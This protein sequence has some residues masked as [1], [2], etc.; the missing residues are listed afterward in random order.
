MKFP[1]SLSPYVFWLVLGFAGNVAAFLSWMTNRS[2][3]FPIY[4]AITA[5]IVGWW[6]CFDEASFLWGVYVNGRQRLW[7]V[8]MRH[9]GYS[10]E[11]LEQ[12]RKRCR[13]DI[14]QVHAFADFETSTGFYRDVAYSGWY[15]IEFIPGMQITVESQG[16]RSTMHTL[17][18][19]IP[20]YGTEHITAIT[21]RAR[22]VTEIMKKYALESAT[23]YAHSP[24]QISYIRITYSL[25]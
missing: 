22:D 12:V 11:E 10:D 16:G 24:S 20:F 5:G 21:N 7:S 3:L 23:V 2:D 9:F 15:Q 18:Q 4:A 8:F 17:Q 1:E 13:Y 14:T 25:S 19:K 6:F